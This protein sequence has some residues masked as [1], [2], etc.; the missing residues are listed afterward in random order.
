MG[1]RVPL[2]V[3]ARP[4]FADVTDPWLR[5]YVESAQTA[6]GGALFPG[7]QAGGPFNPSKKLDRL[8]AA[9]ALVRAAGLEAEAQGSAG[10][11]LAYT[12]AAQIPPQ[13]RGHVIVAVRRGLVPGA[14]AA[15]NPQQSLTRAQLAAAFARIAAMFTETTQSALINL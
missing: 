13:W 2:Y 12:D 8:T 9:V 10:E 7:T 14:G 1:A 15:F 5:S 3:A 6:P 11:T 4:M